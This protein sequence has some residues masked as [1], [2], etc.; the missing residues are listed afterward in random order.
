ML[1]GRQNLLRRIVDPREGEFLLHRMRM[2]QNN[3]DT[4]LA[5]PF[6]HTGK[7][8]GR[9]SRLDR[10][11]GHIVVRAGED[12][13]PDNQSHAAIEAATR[14]DQR[15]R[16]LNRGMRK[17]VVAKRRPPACGKDQP[18]HLASPSRRRITFK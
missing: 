2:S 6:E 3:A 12:D 11:T 16:C 1:D 10:T 4:V 17:K 8:R 7:K 14:D 18:I 13:V 15:S 9:Q 5:P